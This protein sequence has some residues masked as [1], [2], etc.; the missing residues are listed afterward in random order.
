MRQLERDFLNTELQMFLSFSHFK[1]S[2]QNES[3]PR[4]GC[5]LVWSNN[6]AKHI[7]LTESLVTALGYIRYNLALLSLL[8]QEETFHYH[9]EPAEQYSGSRLLVRDMRYETRN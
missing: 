5:S 2:E 3:V 1:S 6:E 4:L 7:F 8:P 9:S